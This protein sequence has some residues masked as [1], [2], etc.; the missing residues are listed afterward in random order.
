METLY[1]MM[2]ENNFLSEKK[3]TIFVYYKRNFTL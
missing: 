2:R 1:G 3:I